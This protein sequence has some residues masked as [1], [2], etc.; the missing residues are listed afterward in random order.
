MTE[1]AHASAKPAPVAQ[2]LF[3]EDSAAEIHLATELL[4]RARVQFDGHWVTTSEDAFHFL[5]HEKGFE[6]APRPHIIFLDLNLPRIPGSGFLKQLRTEESLN[7][8]PVVILSGS[9]FEGDVVAARE[10]GAVHYL[11]KPLNYEKLCEA[12]ARVRSLKLE[13]RGEDLFLCAE[14]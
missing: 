1:P 4:N 6:T 13:T 12:V 10:Q 8:I 7:D 5:R 14:D 9:D 2:V 3:V 11:V